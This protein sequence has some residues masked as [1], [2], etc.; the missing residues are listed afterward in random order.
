M[1]TVSSSDSPKLASSNV[2]A[3]ST[4]ITAIT[5]PTERSMPPDITTT[6]CAAAANANG[7][8]PIAKD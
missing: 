3:A 6:V 1:A 4:F 5:D 7:I 2:A 8:A